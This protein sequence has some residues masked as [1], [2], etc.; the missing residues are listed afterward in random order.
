MGENASRV[1]PQAHRA[2]LGFLAPAIAFG[3]GALEG[4][5][6]KSRLVFGRRGS[7]GKGFRSQKEGST[8]S[9]HQASDGSA[10]DM[11]LGKLQQIS[12]RVKPTSPL[13]EDRFHPQCRP[14]EDPAPAVTSLSPLVMILNLSSITEVTNKLVGNLAQEVSVH[15]SYS[16]IT[17]PDL[18]W[19]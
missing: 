2:V 16:P 13:P 8:L 6:Q 9:I 10:E 19:C 4:Q 3:L 12:W 15:L 5:T 1:T 18:F 17:D 7:E 11:E 14:Q